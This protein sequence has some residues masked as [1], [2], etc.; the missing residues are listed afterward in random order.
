MGL[1]RVPIMSLALLAVLV[2]GQAVA[3]AESRA[4]CRTVPSRILGKR[5][6][7][8]VTL[9]PGYDEDETRQ[10][11]VLYYLHGMGQ[12]EQTL[13]SAGGWDL[14]ERMVQQGRIGEFIM[15]TPDGGRSFYVNS[16][17][18]SQRYED[19]FMEEFLPGIELRY[20]ALG[21]RAGRAIGG[22][23]MGGYGALRFA[24]LYPSQFA[25]VAVHSAALVENMP[26]TLTQSFGRSLRSFGEPFDP[27]YWNAN[28]PFALV[29]D[30]DGLD[31]LRIYFDCGRN[32]DFGFNV[33]AEALHELLERR[34]VPHEFH[35]Y[36]GN[37][38]REYVGE[39]FDESLEFQWS[40]IGK[41]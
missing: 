2:I 27:A 1:S 29:G 13:L 17:D 28:T 34:G 22:V 19:F 37:H 24:F 39:H 11:P 36:P 4:E 14:L 3:Q 8:C 6:P 41:D 33:G 23:S 40:A 9:P 16:K 20:R 5:V 38:S 7:Y 30:A 18:G 21:T 35:L 12:N 10:Y 15:V 32:D 25:S 26:P 31:G